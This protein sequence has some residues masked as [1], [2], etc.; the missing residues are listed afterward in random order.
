MNSFCKIALFLIAAVLGA[1]NNGK[2]EIVYGKSFAETKALAAAAGKPFCIVLSRPDCP[3][4]SDYVRTLNSDE[5]ELS[6]LAVFNIVDTS[7]PEN[8]WYPMWLATASWPSTCIFSPDSKLTAVV[9]GVAQQC[10]SCIENVLRGETECASYF[11]SKHYDSYGDVFAALNDILQCKLRLDAGENIEPEISLTTD[12]MAYPYNLYLKSLNAHNNGDEAT[13]KASAEK[14]LSFNDAFGIRLYGGIMAEAKKIIDPTYSPETD[15]LLAVEK[16]IRLVGCTWGEARPFSIE[17][18]N[19][20]KSR[21]QILD[22]MTSCSCV[23]LVSGKTHSVEPGKSLKIDFEF[24][25]DREGE[26]FR[27][28]SFASN[29]A[30]PIETVE[31]TAT[32]LKPKE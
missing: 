23:S 14:Q 10:I 11:Y 26:V 19:A 5:N 28:V 20:G 22:I 25:G 30:N 16:Q 24:K 18:T 7:K 21:L 13:A 6:K 8:E 1:C 2:Q 27:E 12:K 3:P 9:S 4:C 31:I 32:V 17:I 29:G 15:A